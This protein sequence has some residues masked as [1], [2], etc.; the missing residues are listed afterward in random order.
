MLIDGLK[1]GAYSIILL[2]NEGYP[3]VFYGDM[4]G[5]PH[6]DIPPVAEL[7][8]IIELRKDKAYGKQNDYFDNPNCI[9][10]TLEGDKDHLKSGLAVLISNKRRFCKINVHW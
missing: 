2:R 4:Y 9:G 5:I 8:T 10:W 7:K 3:C 6:D 1:F